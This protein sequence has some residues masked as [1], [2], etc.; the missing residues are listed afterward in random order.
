MQIFS[1]P[2]PFLFEDPVR[3]PTLSLFNC[4]VTVLS[5]SV[6][7]PQS[8][9]PF[10]TLALSVSTGFGSISLNLSLSPN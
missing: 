9:L 1:I 3:N 8:F 6:T 5:Q 10:M 2:V 4:L 7:V